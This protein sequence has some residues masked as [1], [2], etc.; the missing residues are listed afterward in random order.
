MRGICQERKKSVAWLSFEDVI[1][2]STNPNMY[3]TFDESA[4]CSG[5]QVC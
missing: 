3:T 4:W 5:N 2:G 1:A